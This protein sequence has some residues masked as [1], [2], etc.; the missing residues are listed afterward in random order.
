MRE[1]AACK[2]VMLIQRS[3]QLIVNASLLIY[4]T[5]ELCA[6]DMCLQVLGLCDNHIL[7]TIYMYGRVLDISV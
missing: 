7:Y 6:T 1:R 5:S 2:L 3:T 4:I